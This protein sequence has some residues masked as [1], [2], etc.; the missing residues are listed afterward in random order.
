MG[1]VHR[2]IWAVSDAATRFVIWLECVPRQWTARHIAPICYVNIGSP[3]KPTG[4]EWWCHW[5]ACG[6]NA[7]EVEV[8][9][10]NEPEHVTCLDCKRIMESA[11]ARGGE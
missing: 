5:T 2:A 10:T 4:H 6:T 7:E 8:L 1:K 9:C 11:K 3:E